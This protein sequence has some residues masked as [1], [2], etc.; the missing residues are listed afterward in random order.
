MRSPSGSPARTA[1]ARCSRPRPLPGVLGR[2]VTWSRRGPATRRPSRPR[3]GGSPTRWPSPGSPRPPARWRSCRPPTAG[4]VGVL[5]T[6]GLPPVPRGRLAGAA[7]RRALGAGR[8]T[9]LDELRPRCPRAER[10]AVVARPRAAVRAG[11]AS[12]P[13]ARGDRARATCSG[14]T[15]PPA[16]LPGAPSHL[17]VRPWSTR[18]RPSWPRAIA[19]RGDAAP[20]LAAARRRRRTRRGG[21][22]GARR[23]CSLRRR[24]S[25]VAERAGRARG[26]ARSAAAEA[27]RLAGARRCAPSRPCE[28]DLT[29]LAELEERLA[30][31]E[32]A[33]A[34]DEPVDRGPRPAAAPWSP[35]PGRAR[36]RRG[37]PS[38]PR[39]SGPARCTAG[40][41][42]CAGRPR[43]ERGRPRA[44]RRRA[45]RR[46]RGAR[47]RRRRARGRRG[48]LTVLGASLAR[49]AAERDALGAPGRPAR[50]SCS[51][52]ARRV[53]ELDRR[54]RP[55][56]RR[57]APRRGRPRRA[58]LPH[59]A[60]E[61]RAAEEFGVDLATLLAEYGPA[62]LCRR[63]RTDRRDEARRATRAGARCP[64][65][66]PPRSSGPR[67]AERDLATL[68]KV[69]PLALEEFAALEERHGFLATQLEDLKATRR[70]LLDR[71]P[72][73]STSGSSEVF[74]AAYDDVSASSR[75]CSPP[76][77]PAA[78]AAWS[79]PIP[80][81]CSPP[82]S[83]WRPGRR[84]RRSS[85]SRC[86]PGAS[87][88]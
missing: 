63:P 84:A 71:R 3:S 79:S 13:A 1:P 82:A 55:A 19:A 73:R 39:R 22:R 2:S 21:R 76:C 65:T 33:P 14:P 67:K 24:G 27:E 48:A 28:D 62:Q 12:T 9:A 59:R 87:G 53:R 43:Q 25:A 66:A 58:A 30:A 56:D 32:A 5:V 51:T 17:E 64:T 70:D 41:S 54:A 74:A 37:W 40:P 23:A 80:T 16:A 8:V 57:G 6:G 78:R 72:A 46:A 83:R 20:R 26:R 10:V 36:S 81:T 15:G 38:A 35:P 29:A 60:L 31:A 18:P 49:A 7:G 50:P 61:A 52:C 42:R 69:N 75:R 45:S 88:R 68:G 77:S 4:R 11:R 34:E 47:G 44:G 86:C 85:G